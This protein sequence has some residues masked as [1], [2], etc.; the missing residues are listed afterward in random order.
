[1]YKIYVQRRRERN[2][3]VIPEINESTTC[4]FGQVVGNRETRDPEV[5]LLIFT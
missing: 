4:F 3:S 2:A 1:M 5:T